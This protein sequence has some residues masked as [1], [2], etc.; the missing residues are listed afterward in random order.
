MRYVGDRYPDYWKEG[1]AHFDQV[2]QV[3]LSDQA[4]RKRY[5]KTSISGMFF[6]RKQ[7]VTWSDPAKYRHIIPK[8]SCHIENSQ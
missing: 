8:I 7:L 5:L 2:E 3:P 4:A 6:D 1:R